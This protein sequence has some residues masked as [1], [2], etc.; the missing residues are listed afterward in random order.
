M[1]EGRVQS[2]RPVQRL[3]RTSESICERS[4]NTSCSAEKLSRKVQHAWRAGL[5]ESGGKAEMAAECFSRGEHPKAESKRPRNSILEI[6]NLHLGRPMVR[7]CF[8]QR[9][10]RRKTSRRLSRCDERSLLKMMM[11]SM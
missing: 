3:A 9:R 6:T 2:W 11:S 1:A 7:P 10:Q 8:R 4:Q 5:S